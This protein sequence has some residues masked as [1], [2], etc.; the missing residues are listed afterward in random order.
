MKCINICQNSWKKFEGKQVTI[1]ITRM[2]QNTLKQEL[3]RLKDTE[4]TKQEEELQ[5][6]YSLL[7]KNYF[8]TV[9]NRWYILNL[10]NHKKMD[11]D[12]IKM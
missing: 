1:F 8:K 12:I 10:V 7:W 5:K 4:T 3:R 6:T 2:P 11:V 9:E